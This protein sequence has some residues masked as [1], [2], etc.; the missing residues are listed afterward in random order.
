[1]ARKRPRHSIVEAG[2]EGEEAEA[3]QSVTVEGNCVYFY[4]DVTKDTVRQLSKCLREA[5]Q[6]AL[7]H[8]HTLQDPVVFLYIHSDGG[9]AFPGLSAMDWIKQNRVPVTCIAD[10][11]VASAATFMLLAGARRCAHAHSFVLIHQLS[12]SFYGKYADLVD[13]MQNSQSLMDMI[14]KIY[15]EQTAMTSKRIKQLLNKELLMDADM[16]LQEGFVHEILM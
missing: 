3:I 16:C 5:T 12:T 11:M 6:C 14:R 7:K 4:A 10:G 2:E 8:A 15:R 13:E 9:C 1:M